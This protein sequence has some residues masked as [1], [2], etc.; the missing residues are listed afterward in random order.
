MDKSFERGDSPQS[1]PAA[2]AGGIEL[3]REPPH[4]GLAGFGQGPVLGNHS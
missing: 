1:W 3:L 2:V 4:Q